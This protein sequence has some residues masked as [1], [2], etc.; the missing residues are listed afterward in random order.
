M[1]EEETLDLKAS[2]EKYGQFYPIV[3]SQF[4]IVDGKHRELAGGR[5]YKDI[6]VKDL[7]DHW[8]LR[9][10]LNLKGK[11][12][13]EQAEDNRK[14]ILEIAKALKSRNPNIT[15]AELKREIASAALISERT[16]ERYMP[17]EVKKWTVH[18]RA[19]HAEPEDPTSKLRKQTYSALLQRMLGEPYA[20]EEKPWLKEILRDQEPPLR[21]RDDVNRF[22]KTCILSKEAPSTV[23]IR[24]FYMMQGPTGLGWRPQLPYWF[25][26]A[27]RMI[28]ND[29]PEV[30]LY[31]LVNRAITEAK[32]TL[33]DCI[34]KAKEELLEKWN[35][36]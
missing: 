32:I 18:R 23:Y 11:T 5:E 2:I 13:S 26:Y 31:E 33:Q 9:L 14:C 15:Q 30:V 25:K 22:L 12:G 4:G 7:I 21:T 28:G 29:E 27:L 36:K 1:S 3:R 6:V 20:Q 24:D 10:H 8:A 34:A 16:V 17:E 35:L 19:E